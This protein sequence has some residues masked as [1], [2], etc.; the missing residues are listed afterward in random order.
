MFRKIISLSLLTALLGIGTISLFATFTDRGQDEKPGLVFFELYLVFSLELAGCFVI[1]MVF[2]TQIKVSSKENLKEFTKIAIK[3]KN[4]FSVIYD[5]EHKFENIKG[6]LE[7]YFS[8][9][10]NS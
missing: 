3:K 5:K 4:V 7:K 1:F 8:K 9:D 6:R 10:N 2:T